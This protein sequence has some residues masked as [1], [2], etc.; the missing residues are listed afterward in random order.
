MREPSPLI[1]APNGLEHAPFLARSV[2]SE[3]LQEDN[4]MYSSTPTLSSP[5][6][7]GYSKSEVESPPVRTPAE[8]RGVIV[9]DYQSAY[10]PSPS[11]HS[12]LPLSQQQYQLALLAPL[13]DADRRGSRHVSQQL[14]SPTY[15]PSFLGSQQRRLRLPSQL[16]EVD[17]HGPR[18]ISPP[19]LSLPSQRKPK[20]THQ[21]L[22]SDENFDFE[23]PFAHQ[24]HSTTRSLYTTHTNHEYISPPRYG[25]GSQRS[26]TRFTGGEK[27]GFVSSKRKRSPSNSP[28]CRKSNAQRSSKDSNGYRFLETLDEDP[29]AAWSTLP[30]KPA[31]KKAAE[32]SSRSGTFR[33]PGIRLGSSGVKSGIS[34]ASGKRIITFMPPPLHPATNRTP[35]SRSSDSRRRN[36]ASTS[37]SG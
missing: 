18:P 17:L 34:E 15:S 13:S 9:P 23:S 16:S 27:A 6:S 32:R 20:H 3:P 29:D 33:L 30:T 8:Y 12:P 37:F 25:R 36:A 2:A 26:A 35:P 19:Q 10:S 5:N 14:S 1:R 21:Q 22:N 31:K 24:P 7:L 11:S 28:P 4:Y